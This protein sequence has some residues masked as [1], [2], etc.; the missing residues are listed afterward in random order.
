VVDGVD[1]AGGAQIGK[2]ESYKVNENLPLVRPA[3]HRRGQLQRRQSGRDASENVHGPSR[4][5]SGHTITASP[6]VTSSPARAPAR[7]T[8]PRSFRVP[9]GSVITPQNYVSGYEGLYPWRTTSNTIEGMMEGE[10]TNPPFT[11]V[12]RDKSAYASITEGA[13]V[14]YSGMVFQA[15]ATRRCTPGWATPSR[16]PL[17]SARDTPRTSSASPTPP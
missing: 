8:R 13:L 5:R 4:S 11:F 14:N 9:A 10:W 6:S 2:T 16:Q 15:D 7:P 1:L 17:D 3:L 12:L